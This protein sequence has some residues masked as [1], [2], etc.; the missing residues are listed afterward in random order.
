MAKFSRKTAER[1]DKVADAWAKMRPDKRFFGMSLAEFQ[2]ILEP[3]AN[4]CAELADLQV[5]VQH[6]L[7]KREVAMT[8]AIEAVGNVVAGVKGD[9]NE[10]SNGELYAAMGYVTDD[11][12]RTGLKTAGSGE[13]RSSEPGLSPTDC[14]LDSQSEP[15]SANPRFWF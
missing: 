4:A 2:K 1:I 3:F 13:R 5:Q 8:A 11:R 10:G 7:C 12:R 9:I 15:L 14:V 6:A